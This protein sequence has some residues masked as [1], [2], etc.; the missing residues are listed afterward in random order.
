MCH[1][2]LKFFRWIFS[3]SPEAKLAM[4]PGLKSEKI[5][6]GTWKK[7]QAE[8]WAAKITNVTLG[9]YNIERKIELW[10]QGQMKSKVGI[11]YFANIFTSKK[12]TKTS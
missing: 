4:L 11:I 7:L 12:K 9:L 6:L 1:W 10:Q 8:I 5:W 2:Q 3:T